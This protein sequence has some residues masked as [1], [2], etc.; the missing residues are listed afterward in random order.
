MPAIEDLRAV[1]N[2]AK[3]KV[4]E[5][6]AELITARNEERRVAMEQANIE[7]AAEVAKDRGNYSATFGQDHRW[8]GVDGDR[9]SLDFYIQAHTDFHGVVELTRDEAIVLR[10]YLN[11][12]YT[13]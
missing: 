7:R 8:M 6:Q 1:T 10:D 11:A 2:A 9:D 3:E 5:A 12:K 13:D 4:R